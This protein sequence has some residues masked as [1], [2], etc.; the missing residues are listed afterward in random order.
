MVK[1][2][3]K[4]KK[5]Q[6]PKNPTPFSNGVLAGYQGTC[7]GNGQGLTTSEGFVSNIV[8]GEQDFD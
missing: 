3:K 2:K 7:Q 8:V 1:K 4:T 5:P 6:T